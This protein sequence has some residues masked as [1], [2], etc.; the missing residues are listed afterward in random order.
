[1]HHGYRFGDD[2]RP[3]CHSCEMMSRLGVIPFNRMRVH[4]AN[5]M[6]VL[7]EDLP[8]GFPVI[9]LKDTVRELF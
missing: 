8:N 1:M 5:D 3:S 9:C 6:T 7:R 2:F 4:F